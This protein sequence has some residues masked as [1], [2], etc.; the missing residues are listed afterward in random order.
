[1]NRVANFFYG[2]DYNLDLFLDLI[3]DFLEGMVGNSGSPISAL[4]QSLTSL[5]SYHEFLNLPGNVCR[6]C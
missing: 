6:C 5:F 1:M 3:N 4:L 2:L